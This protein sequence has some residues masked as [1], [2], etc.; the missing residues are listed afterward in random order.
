MATLSIPENEMTSFDLPKVCIITGSSQNVSFR[1][2]KFQWYPRW[3]GVFGIAPLIMIIMMMVLMRRAKGELPFSDEAWEAWKKGKMMMA[4][5]TVGAIVLFGGGIA[6]LANR[7][8]AVGA[9]MMVAAV[10]API[11]IGVKFLMGRG[12][13]CT[14]IGDGR[15]DLKIKSDAA[16]EAIRRHLEGGGR[17]SASVAA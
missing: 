10:V 15:I 11:V 14:R 4:L 1:P 16:A 5:G 13:T 17:K 12:P 7:M 3:I 8:E 2:V 6:A 9:L